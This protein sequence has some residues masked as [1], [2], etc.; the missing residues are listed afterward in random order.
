MSIN[1]DRGLVDDPLTMEEIEQIVD[2]HRKNKDILH[3]CIKNGKIE[4]ILPNGTTTN[5]P[6]DYEGF[7]ERS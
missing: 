6:S 1:Y 3:K 5:D 4:F 7:Y 2:F